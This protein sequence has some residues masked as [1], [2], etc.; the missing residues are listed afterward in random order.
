[1]DDRKLTRVFGVLLAIFGIAL[2]IG[3]INLLS[4]GDG[5]YFLA[6]GIG[7]FLSGTLI[8]YGTLLG[9]YMYGATLLMSERD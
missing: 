3:G 2:T 6:V 5:Y 7:V 9:A 1:M 4:M 8:A